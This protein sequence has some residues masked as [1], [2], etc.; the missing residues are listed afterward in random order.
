MPIHKRGDIDALPSPVQTV[1]ELNRKQR[2][3]RFRSLGMVRGVGGEVAHSANI[4]GKQATRREDCS[5]AKG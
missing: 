5:V 3:S 2:E 1:V 4:E